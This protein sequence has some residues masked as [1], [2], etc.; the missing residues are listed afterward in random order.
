ML[1]MDLRSRQRWVR[2]VTLALAVLVAISMAIT[3]VVAFLPYG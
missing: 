1:E 2:W 3:A